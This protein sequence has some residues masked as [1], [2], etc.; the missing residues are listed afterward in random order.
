MKALKITVWALAAVLLLLVLSVF[1]LNARE[2]ANKQDTPTTQAPKPS[3][4]LSWE[5]YLDLSLEEQDAF[6]QT[7]ESAE[8]F[9]KWMESVK[10]T[11]TTTPVLSWDK[12]GKKPN[13]YTWEEYAALSREDQ[14]AFFLWFDS[15]DAFEQWMES[16]KPVDTTDTVPT[17]APTTEP[18]ET[19]KPTDPSKPT[20]PTK[21]TEPTKPDGFSKLPSKYTW[22][23]YQ[24]LSPEKQEIF[25]QWFGS[26][27]A[28]EQWME[29]VKPAETEPQGPTW[30]KPG[31]KPNEY[32]WAEYEA[33]SREDQDAFFQW[34]DST[35]AFEQWMESAKPAE[36]E[37][38]TPTWNKPGK[39]PNEYTWAEYEALTMQEQDAFFLWFGSIDAF[40]RWMN[41]VKPTEDTTPDDDWVDAAKQPNEYTWEEYQALSPEEKDAFFLWFGS[42]EAFESWMES[43]Q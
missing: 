34:F 9:E 14:E 40:E 24:A 32:T 31:K 25:F 43:V 11:E 8:A 1:L 29:S 21:P 23:E 17:E 16:V 19:Q 5:E 4:V 35:A 36:T 3:G 38:T 27:E 41:A 12:P 20:Q 15:V 26:V 10:P 42:V 22:A 30:N 18:E 33:L 6:F 13:A 39:K 28:F 7:F 37:P 2:A